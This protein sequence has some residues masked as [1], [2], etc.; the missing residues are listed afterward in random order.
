MKRKI[1]ATLAGMVA[2][3]T[4]GLIGAP[5]VSAGN[6]T[7][8]IAPV[9]AGQGE[10][11]TAGIGGEVC[12]GGRPLD[13]C[14]LNVGPHWVQVR[15]ESWGFITTVTVLPNQTS[16]QAKI[17]DADAVRVPDG[18]YV[19][20]AVKGHGQAFWGPTEL[21]GWADRFDGTRWM[22]LAGNADVRVSLRRA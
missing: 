18:Y 10:A 20:R 11:R 22:P 1:S 8:G 15:G 19:V 2:L 6:P 14:V 7:A 9:T 17:R 5:A 12:P 16:M 4:L 13:G 21:W 3:C